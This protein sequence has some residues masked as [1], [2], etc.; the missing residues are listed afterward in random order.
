M[1]VLAG[2][3]LPV[4]DFDGYL[5]GVEPVREDT[6]P[7]PEGSAEFGSLRREFVDPVEEHPVWIGTAYFRRNGA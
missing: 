5:T 7:V 4:E 1:L 3:L 2:P 6:G